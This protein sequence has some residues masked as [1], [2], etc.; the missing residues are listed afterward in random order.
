[1][2]EVNVGGNKTRRKWHVY[3]VI[4][5]TPSFQILEVLRDFHRLF[6]SRNSRTTGFLHTLWPD[7]EAEPRFGA[8]LGH[9]AYDCETRFEN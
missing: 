3:C 6:G 7:R 8:A 1:M 4:F 9:S 5:R 2:E